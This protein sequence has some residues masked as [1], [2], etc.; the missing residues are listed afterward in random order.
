MSHFT[1]DAIMESFLKLLEEKR[2]DKIT[3]KDIVLD[4]G[5][6]RKTFYYYFDDIYDLLEKCL[7]DKAAESSSRVSDFESFE[8]ELLNLADFVMKH[9]KAMYHIY[10]SV[11]R[12]K[13]EDYLYDGSVDT[14]TQIIKKKSIGTDCNEE[15]I[16][17][18]S[19]LC[20]NAFTSSVLRWIKDGMKSDLGHILKR[21]T[22]M[23]DDALRVALIKAG[24]NK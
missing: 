24:Q 7:A 23:F 4:C 1:K 13:L 12:D 3:V 2:L 15:D 14:I 20:T 6:S 9:E 17:I 11:S 16:E 19:I 8:K 22:L 5:V 18:V 21:I 10:Y